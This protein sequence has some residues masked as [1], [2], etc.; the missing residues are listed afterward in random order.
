VIT[1]ERSGSLLVV[2]DDAGAR[3]LMAAALRRMG[4]EARCVAGGDQGLR[5]A[6]ESPPLAV[7]LDLLMPGM[8]GFEF[9]DRFRELPHCRRVP[10]IIWTAAD[11]TPAQYQRVRAS[12]QGMVAKGRDGSRAVVEELQAFLPTV[13]MAQV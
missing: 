12:A 1:S 7:V 2:D 6:S 10:V 5:V 9:L 8:D 11:L 13:E 4:Y 3:E